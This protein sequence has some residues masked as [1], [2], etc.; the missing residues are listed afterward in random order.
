M[1]LSTKPRTGCAEILGGCG[2]VDLM[3][4]SSPNSW[5]EAQMCNMIVFAGGGVW[6]VIRS[7]G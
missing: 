4:M 6:E 5:V 1:P 3:F 7:W 2:V